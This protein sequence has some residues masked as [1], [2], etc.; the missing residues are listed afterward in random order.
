MKV[1]VLKLYHLFKYLGYSDYD[2]LNLVENTME[3]KY[4]DSYKM[5]QQLDEFK[6][7]KF[8][9]LAQGPI[10]YTYCHNTSCAI[11]RFKEDLLPISALGI[12][13]SVDTKLLSSMIDT[14][15]QVSEPEIIR[16]IED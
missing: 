13:E 6:L 2:L 8:K 4:S 14:N 9:Q 16:A 12:T 1:Y 10:A 7:V 11:N 15:T 5:Y 3:N